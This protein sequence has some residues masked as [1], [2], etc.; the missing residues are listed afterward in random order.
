M[1]IEK[2]SLLPAEHSNAGYGRRK[3][4]VFSERLH[5]AMRLKN[6]KASRLSD[7]TG[8]DRGS[9]SHY[10]NARYCP[11]SERLSQLAQALGVSESWLRGYDVAPTEPKESV[12]VDLSGR[13]LTTLSLTDEEIMLL[14]KYCD[15]S[16]HSKKIVDLIL[17]NNELMNGGE[18]NESRN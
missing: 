9:I 14:R 1:E 16:G 17:S 3:M 8:I 2:M 4:L 5:E 11:K 18:E 13:R 10:L 6:M 15:A 7:L 12:S